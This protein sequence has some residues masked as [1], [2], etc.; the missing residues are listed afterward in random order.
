MTSQIIGNNMLVLFLQ[1]DELHELG[2]YQQP[3]EVREMKKLVVDTLSNLGFESDGDMEIEVFSGKQGVLVFAEAALKAVV[4]YMRFSDIEELIDAVGA[5]KTLE[6]R[7][8]LTYCMGNYWLE[9]RGA[10]EEIEQATL[11]LS[12]YGHCVDTCEYNEGVLEEYGTLIEENSA[13]ETIRNAFYSFR[14]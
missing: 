4:R 14:S 12:E 9:F 2:L 8:K 13:I 7:S 5:M 11:Q 6:I 3:T 10:K 1:L